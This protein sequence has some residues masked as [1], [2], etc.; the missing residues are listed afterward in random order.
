MAQSFLFT[1][2]GSVP[3]NPVLPVVIM[4]ATIEPDV[5]RIQ[6][7]YQHNGWGGSW[8]YTV[9]DYTHYHPDAHE[10]LTCSHG[11]GD[12]QIGGAKG[13]NFRLVPGDCVVLPAGTGH[14]RMDAA[15]DFAVVGAYPPGQHQPE[16]RRA[17][18]DNHL[19]TPERIAEV[20]LPAT[21]PM[22]GKGGPTMQAW[23]GTAL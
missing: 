19:G 6:A 1:D 7:R 4:S 10:V 12:V 11:W 15:A 2:D 20:P 23:S 21:C 17:T 14:C 18:K 22:L 13:R 8:V 9:F 3:N 16:I 5:E